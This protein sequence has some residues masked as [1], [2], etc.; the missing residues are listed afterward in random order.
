MGEAIIK[1]GKEESREDVKLAAE[2]CFDII[3]QA[4][5]AL[6]PYLS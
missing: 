5:R 3:R 1:C 2:M 4:T 6:P